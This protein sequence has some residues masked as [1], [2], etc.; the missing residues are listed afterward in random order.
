MQMVA[1]TDT[2]PDRAAQYLQVAD[3]DVEQ[4]VSLFF[5]SGG[6]DLGV[7]VASTRQTGAT[8][9][10]H[11]GDVSDP[12]N[13]DDDD[14]DNISDDNNAVVTGFNKRP[15]S[16]RATEDDEAMARRLQ[17]EMYSSN[18]G[19]QDVRAPIAR[20]TEVLAGPGATDYYGGSVDDAVQERIQALQNRRGK[21]LCLGRGSTRL[22]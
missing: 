4:A 2:T 10:T 3:G 21:P 8:P 11:T 14:D 16:A 22:T 1:I 13:V 18:G 9:R 20:T 5:E 12:I 7:A 19:E 15:T 6:V 17:E